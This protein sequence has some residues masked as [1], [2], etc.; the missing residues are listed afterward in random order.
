MSLKSGL[1]RRAPDPVR[2]AV[3]RVL[4]LHPARRR[5][6][7]QRRRIQQHV[8]AATGRA[9]QGGPFSGLRYVSGQ[10]WGWSVP[11]LTGSY[12]SELHPELERLIEDRPRTV[13][14]VGCAEGYYAVGLAL[15]LPGATVHA[16]DLDERAQR[17]CQDM[18][19]LNDVSER[20]HVNAECTI[21]DLDRLGGPS[22]LLILDCEGFE[23]ELLRPDLASALTETVILVEMHDFVDPTISATILDRFSNTHHATVIRAAVKSPGDW[24][25]LA[26][27]T[28]RD[29]LE[30]LD[31]GRPT[32]PNPMEWAVLRPAQS[33][34]T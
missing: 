27:L 20:V 15:R 5:R 7:V 25:S 29:Q 9:V 11:N 16:F 6:V 18:A 19:S 3:R 17:L 30:A 10:S 1:S 28:E 33:G 22:T 2:A 21:D 12:E 14:D 32:E 8:Q 26:G 23:L 31:E 24:P 34:G 4:D 13:V